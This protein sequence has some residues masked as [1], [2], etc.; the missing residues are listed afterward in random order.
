MKDNA[1]K[2]IIGLFLLVLAVLVFV[3][4]ISVHHI[5]RARVGSDWVNHTHAVIL[6]GNAVVSYL[7]AGDAALRTYLL[8]HDA[9]DQA[10]YRIAYSDMVE[11]LQ[12]AEALTRDEPSQHEVFQQLENLVSNH[13][14]SA[15]RW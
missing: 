5:Y 2:R 8:T 11:H 6:E 4:I 12:T 13:V 1:V 14:D 7:H 10:P 3:A 15:G 9:R